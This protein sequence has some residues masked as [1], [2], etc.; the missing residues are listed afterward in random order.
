MSEHADKKGWDEHLAGMTDASL[1]R[2]LH[3]HRSYEFWNKPGWA[4]SKLHPTKQY[5]RNWASY[6]RREGRRRGLL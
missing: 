4:K 2:T 6:A 5:V 3:T 1:L